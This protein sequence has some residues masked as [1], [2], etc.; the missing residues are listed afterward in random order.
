MRIEG[1]E[2]I[3]HCSECIYYR[4]CGPGNGSRG[5]MWCNML[6][7]RITA[8]KKPCKFYFKEIGNAK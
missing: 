1:F 7:R 2:N 5:Y 4:G 3:K 6:M 8:R